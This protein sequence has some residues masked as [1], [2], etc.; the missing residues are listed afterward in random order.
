[1]NNISQLKN[2]TCCGACVC[3]CPVRAITTDE[4][5]FYKINVDSNA[6]ISCGKCLSVCP[7]I[8][9]NKGNGPI[10]AVG[11]WTN[12]SENRAESS[13]GGVFSLLADYVLSENGVVFGA[14][15]SDDKKEVVF[16]ST[17][18][19]S[20]SELRRSKYVESYT[21]DSFLL[22]R[23]NLKKGRLVLFCGTPCQV[24]GLKNFLKTEYQNLILCDF[25]CGGLSSHKVF[26]DYLDELEKKNKSKVVSVIFRPKECGWSVY[27]IL[28]KFL[29]R[30]Q[31]CKLGI[32]DPFMYSFAYGRV[33]IRENC[34]DCMFS[35]NH[36]SDITIADYW[37]Y[38]DTPEI[39]NDEKGISLVTANTPKGLEMIDVIAKKMMCY[40][41]NLDKALYNYKDTVHNDRKLKERKEFFSCYEASGLSKAAKRCG[42]PTGLK[43]CVLYMKDKIRVS[44]LSRGKK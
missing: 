8:N 35:N 33:S 18:T 28:I 17:D 1:M 39:T 32:L 16:D 11:G 27:H 25:A 14:R 26:R 42:M 2:C 31:Y 10:K 38:K 3:A 23:D 9:I 24:A 44:K 34:Y 30:K 15:F 43:Y 12:H 6:C 41:L 29:N 4:G 7:V 36:Y 40:E 13:S 20:L 19:V 37:R 22:V 21:G 5:L